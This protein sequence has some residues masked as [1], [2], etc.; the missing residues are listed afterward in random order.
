VNNANAADTV[1]YLSSLSAAKLGTYL[2]PYCHSD[3][4]ITDKG[5]L[6]DLL[7]PDQH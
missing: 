7:I 3:N 1:S 6:E 2:P 5:L 4:R